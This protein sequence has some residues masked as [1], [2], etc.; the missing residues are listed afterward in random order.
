V[1]CL[2]RFRCSLLNLCGPQ[3]I[4]CLLPNCVVHGESGVRCRIMWSAVNQ[5]FVA[6]LCCP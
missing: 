3:R 6:E 1:C 2:Q 5:V 4:R